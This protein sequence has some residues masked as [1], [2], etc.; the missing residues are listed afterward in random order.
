MSSTLNCIWDLT[1]LSIEGLYLETYKVKGKVESSR[2]AYGGRIKHTVVCD[3]PVMLTPIRN[4]P[5]DR[6]IIDDEAIS[7]VFGG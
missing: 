5:A 6:L 4:E 2:V 1:G 7:R 3:P